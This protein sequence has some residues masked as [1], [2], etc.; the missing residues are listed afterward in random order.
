MT[1]T[2]DFYHDFIEHFAA[3]GKEREDI[4]A[5]YII[6][7][8]ARKKHPADQWSDLDVLLYTDTPEYYLNT[9]EFLQQF[10]EIWSSFA[11]KTLGNDMERLTLFDGGY[12]VDLVT[13]SAQE[14]EKE[15]ASGTVP[16]LFKRG[17]CLILDNTGEAAKLLPQ[18]DVLPEKLPL[19][20]ATFS[21]VNQMFWFVT[22]YISKQLLR[23]ESWAAKARDMD[24]KNIIL[25][26]IEWYELSVHGEE[27]DTWHG[28]RFI[29]DWAEPDVYEALFDIFGHFDLADSW[30]ALE[31]SIKLFSDLTEKIKAK[32]GFTIADDLSRNVTQW[33]ADKND[34]FSLK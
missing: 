1:N 18:E 8:R 28:G 4:K 29:H 27:Y 17:A 5:A 12:Q 32:N 33:I 16:W 13:K 21:E 20:E 31:K 7:S 3:V 2:Q 6:G 25:Q 23:E 30:T 9:S 22:M 11:T 19:N 10:G 14:Y 34:S 26:M 24:Y 15:L